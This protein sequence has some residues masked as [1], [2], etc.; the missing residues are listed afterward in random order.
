MP[1]NNRVHLNCGRTGNISHDA[2][3]SSTGSTLVSSWSEGW[4]L[5]ISSRTIAGLSALLI[6]SRKARVAADFLKYQHPTRRISMAA[7]LGWLIGNRIKIMV[8]KSFATFFERS[9]RAGNPERTLI[10]SSTIHG[11]PRV[12]LEIKT[13]SQSVYSDIC[14]RHYRHRKDL[15]CR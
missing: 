14:E 12:P 3:V 8:E 11:C 13:A 5:R 9:S 10:A 6:C 7:L 4:K 1:S 2:I 15:H